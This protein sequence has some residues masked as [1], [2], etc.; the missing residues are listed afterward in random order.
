[1]PGMHVQHAV[2]R[3][4]HIRDIISL[5]QPTQLYWTVRTHRK[6]IIFKTIKKPREK[7]RGVICESTGGYL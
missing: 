6:F 1:M 5:A 2:G 3:G 7:G 4:Q